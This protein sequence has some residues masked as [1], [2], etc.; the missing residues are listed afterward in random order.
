MSDF[1]FLS[2]KV[3]NPK[4][5]ET[6]EIAISSANS[7]SH[8]LIVGKPG[9]GKTA[10]AKWIHQK[11]RLGKSFQ[12]LTARDVRDRSGLLVESLI[13][14][15]EGT[16][17]LEDIDQLSES[18][19]SL[20]VETL[21]KIDSQPGRCRLISTSRRDLR[22]LVR[23][24]QFRQD[25]YYKITVLQ[26]QLPS[27]VERGED[28]GELV[29]F[30][31]E[32]QGILQGKPGLGFTDEAMNQLRSWDWPGNIREL[33]NVVERAVALAHGSQIT[34]SAVRFD[35]TEQIDHNEFGPGM[36]LSEVEKKLILQ[37][38]ELTSQNR[39]RAAQMLGISIRTLRNKLNEYRGEGTHESL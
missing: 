11:G 27:L 32:V 8:L 9:T 4:M 28:L 1:D 19:Q 6:I 21:Q 7:P 15:R 37:T 22:A 10:L 39:T 29:Q 17:V 18:S 34:A 35:P 14:N 2:Q 36:S 23:S 33:E 5:I 25:L 26:V 12:I 24:G 3:T 20:L 13:E 38:L 30:L 31:L 16:L